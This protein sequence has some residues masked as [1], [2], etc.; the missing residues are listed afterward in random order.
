MAR[1]SF[2]LK[3]VVPV[4][5]NKA[6]K[7]GELSKAEADALPA[8][9]QRL[10]RSGHGAD[11][12]VLDGRPD[13]KLNIAAVKGL[14]TE[15]RG[16]AGVVA[17]H[18]RSRRFRRLS[19]KHSWTEASSYL[20]VRTATREFRTWLFKYRSAV[21]NGVLTAAEL[22]AFLD[23]AVKS[24]A[25][26]KNATPEDRVSARNALRVKNLA[27][28]SLGVAQV[29]IQ[30]GRTRSCANSGVCCKAWMARRT[31]TSGRGRGHQVP[32]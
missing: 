32:R 24:L 9:R 17:R 22:N 16:R 19:R 21:E 4:D 12:D 7:P 29:W 30:S 25:A 5:L 20:A 28:A 3:P 15:D 23:S 1:E 6:G 10:G 13:G 8:R 26:K 31:R 14:P 18:C 2:D 27:N 11:L